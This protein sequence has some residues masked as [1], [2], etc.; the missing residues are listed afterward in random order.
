MEIGCYGECKYETSVIAD[1]D[2]YIKKD[3]SITPNL[4]ITK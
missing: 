2:I 4:F 1:F 3:Y